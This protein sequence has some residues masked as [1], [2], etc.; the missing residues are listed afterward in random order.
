M[1]VANSVYKVSTKKADMFKQKFFVPLLNVNLRWRF[2]F[3][4]IS[5]NAAFYMVECS[6]ALMFI[7]KNMVS[8]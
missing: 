6:Y 3:Y 5:P 8:P 1:N 7:I 4:L 2:F